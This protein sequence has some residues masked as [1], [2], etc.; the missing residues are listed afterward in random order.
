MVDDSAPAPV[1]VFPGTAQERPAGVV[2]SA[3]ALVRAL[4]E[5]PGPLGVTDLASA[6]GIPK[7]TAHRLLDH[8]I[9]CAARRERC[10]LP[11]SPRRSSDRRCC[12]RPPPS[13]GPSL[14][15]RWRPSTGRCTR[16]ASVSPLPPCFRR[17]GRSSPL[18]PGRSTARWSPSSVP[19]RGSSP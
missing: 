3:F 10:R 14:P 2:R 4:S 18:S 7:T 6:V 12:T 19:W 8:W 11:W 9:P 15:G 13:G 5:A 16:D 1:S 17:A